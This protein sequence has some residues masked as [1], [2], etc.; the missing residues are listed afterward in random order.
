V[1]HVPGHSPGQI[2]LWREADRL[3]LLADSVY[4]LDFETGRPT[5]ARV[6]HVAV[7]WDSDMARASIARLAELGP[8]TAWAGH[9]R[10]VSENAQRELRAAAEPR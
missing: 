4:T 2:A 1:I 9:S 3:L 7:N 5:P 10:H 6:P 8:L